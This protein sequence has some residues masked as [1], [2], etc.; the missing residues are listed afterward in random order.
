MPKVTGPK[1]YITV[2]EAARSLWKDR[3]ISSV[4]SDCVGTWVRRA[5]KDGLIPFIEQPIG[6][7]HSASRIAKLVKMSDVVKWWDT[8]E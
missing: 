4:T 5:C 2:Q 3:A 7:P 6:D 1:G 8:N